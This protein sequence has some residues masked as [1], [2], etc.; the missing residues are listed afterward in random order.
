MRGGGH[1]IAGHGVAA[2]AVV[3]DLGQLTGV[4][5]DA[6]ARLAIVGPGCRWG[7]LIAAGE[8]T[9]L[10]TP[11]GYNPRV[12]V[13]GLTLGGGY[14]AL[15]RA[16]GMA[17]D[18]L[19]AFELILADGTAVHVDDSQPELLWAGRG[20]GANFG[21]VTELRLR[22]HPIGPVFVSN[23]TFPVERSG[24]LLRRYR[25]WVAGVPD[26][27]TA[28]VGFEGRGVFVAAIYLGE[29]SEGERLMA[30][31]RALGPPLEDRSGPTSY[32]AIHESNRD[33]FPDGLHNAWRSHFIAGLD[34]ATIAALA[35]FAGRAPG[36]DFY[37]VLE[38][39]GGKMAAP[40]P[41]ATAFPHRGAA[42]GVAIAINWRPKASPARLLELAD[43]L[44]AALAPAS[45]GVYA[46]YLGAGA[47]F[48]EVAAAYGP[49]LPR[50]RA[51]KRR[52]DPDNVFRSNVNI[53]PTDSSAPP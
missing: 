42:F 35:D 38:H 25:D 51:L 9:D 11:G 31:L 23:L 30:P 6:A 24:E 12:G 46:N 48:A 10:A 44:H 2:G 7:D 4:R 8:P 20:A 3:I 29:P 28:Y 50:L 52:Y 27:L 40:A 39:L 22:L 19:L 17:C 1:S 41:A 16:H 14:G 34:D 18:S 36:T 21:I 43:G 49:N 47:S 13:S 45:V 5:I 37:F 33:E 26:A 53:P 15:T 32:A